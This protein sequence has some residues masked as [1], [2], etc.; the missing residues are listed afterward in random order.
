MVFA[1]ILVSGILRDLKEYYITFS[2]KRKTEVGHYRRPLLLY[3]LLAPWVIGSAE[4]LGNCGKHGPEFLHFSDKI[5]LD[6]SLRF[7]YNVHF[8]C[9]VL[10][11]LLYSCFSINNL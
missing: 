9:E 5:H 3:L 11:P 8:L 7:L 6:S 2:S 1:G 4:N 10:T